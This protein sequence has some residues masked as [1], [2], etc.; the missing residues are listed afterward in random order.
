VTAGRGDT[1]NLMFETSVGT[2]GPWVMRLD[3][4]G[5]L[6][7]YSG[8]GTPFQAEAERVTSLDIAAAAAA[9]ADRPLGQLSARDTARALL[10]ADTLWV[11]YGRP[12]RRGREIFGSVVPWNTVWRAGANTATHFRTSADVVIG[13]TAVPAGT[14]T[15]WALPAPGGWKLIVNRQTG[16]WGTVYDEKQDLARIDMRVE[17]LADPVERFTIEIAPQGDGAE[18]RMAWDRTRAA[19]PIARRK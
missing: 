2:F 8:K 1:L 16:Q 13:G 15:L 6:L 5:R 10:G 4:S 3:S 9:F 7:S 19:V 14:Y 17:T 11:D 12:A 18:L